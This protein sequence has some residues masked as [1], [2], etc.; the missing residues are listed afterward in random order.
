MMR[1]QKIIKSKVG[2]D[3]IHH[4]LYVESASKA[5]AKP[6]PPLP[7]LARYGPRDGNFVLVLRW[8]HAYAAF[9][10]RPRA[11]TRVSR[12]SMT[13]WYRRSS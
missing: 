4:A 8:C 1:D 13:R 7:A 5:N 10:L 2:P 6:A 12:S 11:R 3:R 9:R